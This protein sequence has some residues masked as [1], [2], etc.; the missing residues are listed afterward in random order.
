VGGTTAIPPN[1]MK[2]PNGTLYDP[3]NDW[4]E[5]YSFRSR[6]SGGLQFALCDGSVRFVKESITTSNY[7]AMSTV[8]G[9]EVVS[10][11]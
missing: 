4:P 11:D 10:N 9:G 2:R 8:S 1:V 6:H 5:L 3:Y 7:R